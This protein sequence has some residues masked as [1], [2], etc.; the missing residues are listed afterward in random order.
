MAHETQVTGKL[1]EMTVARALIANGWEVSDPIVDEIYDLVAKDP[2]TGDFKTIQVKTIRRR[3]DRNN[4]MVMY[5]TNG[6]GNAYQPQD[7]DYIAGVEGD[8]VYLTEC[9]GIKEYWA[10]DKAASDRWVKFTNDKGIA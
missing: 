7:C 5:A 3:S 8:N 9:R 2:L 6:K 10:S 4:E 1:S